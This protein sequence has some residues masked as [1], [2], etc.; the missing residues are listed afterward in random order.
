MD[1]EDHVRCY[2]SYRGVVVGCKVVQ[3]GVDMFFG[4]F[5][6]LCLFSGDA[7]EGNKSSDVYCSGVVHDGAHNLLNTF[8]SVG[9]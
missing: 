6:G 2:I 1:V 7:A 3:E 4:L 5:G 8:Y 9:W